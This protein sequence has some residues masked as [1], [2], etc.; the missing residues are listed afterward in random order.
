MGR[1][2]LA[3]RPKSLTGCAQRTS[4][5]DLVSQPILVIVPVSLLVL[6]MGHQTLGGSRN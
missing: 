5:S 6:E 2:I 4:L 1:L 3:A